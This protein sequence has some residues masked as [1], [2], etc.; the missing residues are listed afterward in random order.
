MDNRFT[1]AER[2]TENNWAL[3]RKQKIKGGWQIQY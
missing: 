2:E 3:I 1:K